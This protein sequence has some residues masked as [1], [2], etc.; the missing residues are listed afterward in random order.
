VAQGQIQPTSVRPIQ[1]RPTEGTVSV[2]DKMRYI[3]GQLNLNEQQKQHADSLLAVL[4]VEAKLS[5]DALKE[6]LEQIQR[7]MRERTAAAQAGDTARVAELNEELNDLQLQ[8]GAERRFLEGLRPALDEAQK[9]KLETILK[10]L[11]ASPDAALKPIHIVRAAHELGLSPEQNRALD[12]VVQEFRKKIGES[13]ELDALKRIDLLDTFTS[14]VRAVL[15]PDQQQ[16][17]DRK[18]EELRLA[19]PTP[20]PAPAA[21]AWPATRP[22]AATPQPPRPVAPTPPVPP[23]PKK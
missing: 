17:F 2:Q 12:Q 9:A 14:Q 3:I 16:R 11:E 13:G 5:G 1:P 20:P 18:V 7:V 8:K 6:R 23:P 21:P 19:P 15:N 4:E 22:A 10:R